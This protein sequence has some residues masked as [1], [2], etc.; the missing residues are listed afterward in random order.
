MEAR[1]AC[2]GVAVDV[3][4]AGP[5]ILT[6]LAQAL[7]HVC[8]ALVPYEAGKAQAGEGIHFV[9]TGASVLAGVGKAIID[10]LLTVHTTEAGR[11]LAHVAALSIMADAMVHTRLGDTLINVN[12]ASLTLPARGTRAGEALKTECLFTNSTILTRVRGAGSQ[13]CLTILACVRQH[14]VAGVAANIINAGSLVQARV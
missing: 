9:H 7:I 2:A 11:T 12:G 4:R 8:L 10:V 1:R 14:A 3:V 13:H 6:G 5:P